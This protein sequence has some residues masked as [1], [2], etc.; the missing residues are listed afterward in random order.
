MMPY[1]DVLSKAARNK[2]H[3]AIATLS[4]TLLEAASSTEVVGSS[5]GIFEGMEDT[6]N[7]LNTIRGKKRTTKVNTN[8]NFL[9]SLGGRKRMLTVW[10]YVSR[11][12]GKVSYSI[13]VDRASTL[14]SL[15]I[16]SPLMMVDTL[17][18][19]VAWLGRLASQLV[20]IADDEIIRGKFRVMDGM[21]FL[22]ACACVLWVVVDC[23]WC[24]GDVWL[25]FF[26][27]FGKS[28]P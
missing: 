14:A 7:L 16:A 27:S 9:F 3:L 13:E 8:A 28:H 15:A 19:R 25:M 24:V 2:H 17:G 20:P 1:R 6:P 12:L 21:S 5:R 11:P 4:C 22:C 10:K 18:R 26:F 23:V